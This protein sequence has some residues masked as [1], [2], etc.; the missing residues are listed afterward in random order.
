MPLTNVMVFDSPGLLTFVPTNFRMKV[1][2]SIL[3]L[4]IVLS[5]AVSAKAQSRWSLE[6]CVARAFEKNISIKQSQLNVDLAEIDQKNAFGNLLPNLNAQASHGYNWGQRIDP[7][8]NQFATERIRSNSL[9]IS[10][11][12]NLFNGFQARNALEQAQINLMASKLNDEKARNDIALNVSSLYL[13]VLM[14]QEMVTIAQTNSD[15]TENQAK[16]IRILVNAGQ[17]AQ[18]NLDDIDA[19]LATDQASLV[20]AKN[21]YNLSVLSLAQALLLSP[22]E[23]ATFQIESPDVSAVENAQLGPSAEAAVQYALTHFPEMKSAEYN[24]QSAEIGVDIAK[25]AQLPSL[26]ASFSYGT[27]YSG[28]ASTVVGDPDFEV[29]PIGLV[30]ATG[31]VVVSA[32]PIYQEDDFETISFG[33]QLTDNVNKSLFFSL[34]IP[35]FNGFSTE[36]SIKRSEINRLNAEYTVETTRQNLRQSVERAYAD[37]LA[38]KANFDAGTKSV[39]AAEKAFQNTKSRYEQGA[40]TQ[41]EYS[42]ARSRLDNAKVNLLNS[43][44]EYLFRIKVLEFYQGQAIS[45]KP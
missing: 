28:A 22:E 13:A 45:L 34:N 40:S 16:R 1:Y 8:T 32:Q 3:T 23:T 42:D 21:N 44:Y 9:G 11:S 39:Q 29:F 14:N 19:Q 12:V 10:T 33:D 38:A 36:S 25:G 17:L 4:L 26:S 27:G 43:K 31:D 20:Q 30:Q 35:I 6:A 15:N 41:V 18:N 2:K 37:A 5:V 24:M 7:F